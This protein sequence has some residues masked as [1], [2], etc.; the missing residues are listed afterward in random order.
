MY[1][2]GEYNQ[3][4]SNISTSSTNSKVINSSNTSRTERAR[5]CVDTS[6]TCDGL[7]EYNKSI[8]VF[9][10]IDYNMKL[11]RDFNYYTNDVVSAPTYNYAQMMEQ[12]NPVE[13][14][15][16]NLLNKFLSRIG[17]NHEINL[18]SSLTS[19]ISD[20]YLAQH[21]STDLLDEYMI[22]KENANTFTIDSLT[23]AL[24]YIL[25]RILL[26]NIT[27]DEQNNS[28]TQLVNQLN[29]F[30][31]THYTRASMESNLRLPQ[32]AITSILD[33]SIIH[34]NNYGLNVFNSTQSVQ[35]LYSLIASKYRTIPLIV[36]ISTFNSERI[37][38]EPLLSS[39]Q[40]ITLNVNNNPIASINDITN[41]NAPEHI[42][43]HHPTVQFNFTTNANTKSIIEYLNTTY[44][45]PSKY[46][47]SFIP[48]PYY[49]ELFAVA[50]DLFNDYRFSIAVNICKLISSTYTLPHNSPSFNI[51][52]HKPTTNKP[53]TKV[54]DN[55][56]T[57]IMDVMVLKQSH[58]LK[59]QHFQRLLLFGIITISIVLVSVYYLSH[60]TSVPLFSTINQQI[61]S[62][63][64]TLPNQV[65]TFKA[66]R[67]AM[68]RGRPTVL[69]TL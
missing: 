32:Q 60:R 4:L 8:Q 16:E 59:R 55:K 33:Y 64:D 21:S 26:P 37:D 10:Y 56:P 19:F 18:F 6:T 65:E 12:P 63:M 58:I 13:T 57:S 40:V 17:T 36:F 53:L 51:L 42:K 28:P 35:A 66:Y 9:L 68:N 48:N 62:V 69:D 50:R 30:L 5:E 61:P 25:Q 54:L 47:S 67:M 29:Q 39:P 22:L 46:I 23:N 31:S 14:V 43:S 34:T 7:D 38:D 1:E 20:L 52:E 49:R 3:L 2:E 45:T 11:Q 27:H 24:E 15:Y 44:A 41:F